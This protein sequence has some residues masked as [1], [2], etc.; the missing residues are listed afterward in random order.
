MCVCAEKRE[1]C[2]K[3]LLLFVISSHLAVCCCEI[4]NLKRYQIIGMSSIL[5]QQVWDELSERK[6]LAL[7]QKS[8]KA[9][10]KVL[11]KQKTYTSTNSFA[12]KVGDL[13]WLIIAVWRQKKI[14]EEFS[15]VPF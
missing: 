12:I 7:N 11:W 15:S 5:K 3:K 6:Y 10:D 4:K 2:F 14:Y 9:G 13:S 8:I 1:T